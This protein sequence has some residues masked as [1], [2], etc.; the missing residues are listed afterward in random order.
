MAIDKPVLQ[1]RNAM[2]PLAAEEVER[3]LQKLPVNVIQ[4]INKADAIAYALNRLPSMYATTEEG[5]HWQQE[6]A[7]ESLSNLIYRAATWGIKA[8]ARKAKVFPT[9]LKDKSG[10]EVALQ[11]LKELL[12]CEEISWDTLVAV[13]ERALIQTESRTIARVSQ[14]SFQQSGDCPELDEL[15]TR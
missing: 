1:Y 5:W 4:S 3:Q 13:V 15:L 9:P 11:Q 12:D 14:L 6:R 7:K 2:E 10:S 8:A